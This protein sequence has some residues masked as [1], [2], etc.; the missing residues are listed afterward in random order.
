[1]IM[2]TGDMISLEQ[3]FSIVGFSQQ[4]IFINLKNL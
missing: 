1:M 2:G 3:V 4:T